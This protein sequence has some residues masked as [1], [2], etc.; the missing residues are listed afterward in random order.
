MIAR[1]YHVHTSYCDGKSTPEEVVISAMEKGM[2][3]I[4]FSGHSYTFFDESYCMTKENTQ[5]YIAHINELKEKYSDKITILCGIEQDYFSLEPTQEYDYVIGSVH[6]VKVGEEYFSVDHTKDIF[7]DIAHSC[8]GGD[9]YSFAE[10]Y[11]ELVGN[12]A[13]VVKPQIIGHFDLITKFN[14]GN[15][16]F[17]P[18]HP[19]YVAAWK[20]AADKLLKH[21]IPFEIN[22]GAISRGYRTSPYPDTDIIRYIRDNGGRF[23]LSSDSHSADNLM[24]GFDKLERELNIT[25]IDL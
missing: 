12:V 2:K 14:E 5:R 1:D 20:A 13:S 10:S 6:Y 9:Y 19:R 11:Y 7:T 8:F 24:Y 23:I 15:V 22:T 3:S 4:G 18:N 17:D 25:E 16:F 21:D